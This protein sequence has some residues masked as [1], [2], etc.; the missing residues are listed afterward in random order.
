[1]FA[2]GADGAVPLNDLYLLGVSGSLQRS[3]AMTSSPNSAS[4]SGGAKSQNHV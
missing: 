3:R 2:P 4:V 1:M